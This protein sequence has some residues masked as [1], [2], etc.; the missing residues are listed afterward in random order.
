[1][2]T[3]CSFFCIAVCGNKERLKTAGP[4]KEQDKLQNILNLSDKPRLIHLIPV[5]FEKK[6]S[7]LNTFHE[8]YKS[9]QYLYNYPSPKKP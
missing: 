3:H 7:I 5:V 4:F 9:A 1:M 2:L 6:I 8:V